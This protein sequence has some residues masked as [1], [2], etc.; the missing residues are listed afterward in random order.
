MLSLHTFLFIEVKCF[1][2]EGIMFPGQQFA[3][4]ANGTRP[5]LV[6]FH[7]KYQLKHLRD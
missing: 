4:Q 3:T 6:E 2:Y 7:L 1:L 5:G